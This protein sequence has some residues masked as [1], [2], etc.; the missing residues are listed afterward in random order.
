MHG[1]GVDE[2]I[3]M[4]TGTSLASKVYYHTDH[5]GSTVAT[6]SV[7]G[8]STAGE[9][10]TYSP[11]GEP[12]V[13]GF[14]GNP[15]RY[16]GRR[17]DEETGLYYYRARYYDPAI[18]RFLQ[19]DPIGYGDGMNTYAYAR[20]DPANSEDP[21]GKFTCEDNGDG[22]QTCT[23]DGSILDNALLQA[24]SALMHAIASEGK[25]DDTAKKPGF[26]HNS[27]DKP[28]GNSDQGNNDPKPPMVPPPPSFL[29]DKS[30]SVGEP[31]QEQAPGA[32]QLQ[33]QDAPNLGNL[34]EASSRDLQ[35]AAAADGYTRVE[36]WKTQ[37]LNLN[38]RDQIMKDA[39]G[40]LYSVPR[41]GSGPPQA[42][43][44]RL[45]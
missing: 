40:N 35:K 14:T 2:R 27:G 32:P 6:S 4:Y 37:E 1:A 20:N 21:T 24:Y 39:Q 25:D 30:D 19:T 10:Y 5:Q 12:G 7:A 11:Y 28:K 22:T 23:S 43:G 26:G 41:Q 16:T 3:A 8:A 45:P 17:L 15:F 29:D 33:Q 31:H 38:S 36:T 34:R 42:L 44:V 13:E 18:G 9:L